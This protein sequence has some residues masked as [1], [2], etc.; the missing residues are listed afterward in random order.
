MLPINVVMDH[1]RLEVALFASSGDEVER[2][3]LTISVWRMVLVV[4]QLLDMIRPGFLD[5]SKSWKMADS[6]VSM[7][8]KRDTDEFKIEADRQVI[9]RG[10]KVAEVAER[11]GVHT[12]SLY[13]WLHKLGWCSAPRWTRAPYPAARCRS[14][15]VLRTRSSCSDPERN[16]KDLLTSD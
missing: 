7:S 10:F 6:E 2:F 8:S 11:L 5:I 14:M 12:H 3:D 16:R 15:L 9:N 13:A 4:D 1:D